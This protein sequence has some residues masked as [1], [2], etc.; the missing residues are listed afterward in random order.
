[1]YGGLNRDFYFD[2]AVRGITRPQTCVVAGASLT[3][4]MAKKHIHSLNMVVVYNM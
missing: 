4:D 2:D 3:S 1:M